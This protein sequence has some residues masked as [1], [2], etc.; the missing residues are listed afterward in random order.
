MFQNTL[1][2]IILLAIII[3][4]RGIVSLN[5]QFL[6]GLC[7][8][9]FI[10]TVVLYSGNSIKESLEQKKQDL[11]IEHNQFI[12]KSKELEEKL[13][14]I[15]I[16]RRE[17]AENLKLV[18]NYLYPSFLIALKNLTNFVIN[19]LTETILIELQTILQ[20]ESTIIPFIQ[21]YLSNFIT[22]MSKTLKKIRFLALMDF[23]ESET[24]EALE[25]YLANDINLQIYSE[26]NFLQYE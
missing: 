12:E 25:E 15:L 13:L 23:D 26:D 5:E 24:K 17:F 8:V 11:I 7:F 9:A 16:T 2:F 18:N 20:Y 21:K 19:G 6:V 22:L 14:K 3:F 1:A 4:S 10:T